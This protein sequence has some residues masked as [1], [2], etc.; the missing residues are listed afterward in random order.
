MPEK[1]EKQREKQP[2]LDVDKRLERVLEKFAYVALFNITLAVLSNTL[3]LVVLK[4]A[5]M[6]FPFRMLI[7]TGFSLL[8]LYSIS[9]V[10]YHYIEKRFK[11]PFLLC[12]KILTATVSIVTMFFGVESA[13]TLEA[14][15]SFNF[16][17]NLPTI[18]ALIVGIL[19]A[20]IGLIYAFI[21]M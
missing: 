20:V 16:S 4:N 5:D 10:Y 19:S 7:L 1:S 6:L 3:S 17:F 13:L 2:K 18:L 15:L 14:W 9:S 12:L 8:L 11:A 21:K